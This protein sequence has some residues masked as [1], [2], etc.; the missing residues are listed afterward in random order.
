MDWLLLLF[1]GAFEVSMTFGLGKTRGAAGFEFC[2]C[3][4][5]F[6]I[7]AALSMGLLAKASQTLPLGT[8]YAVRTGI[9]AVG[10]VLVGI[11]VFKEP[12]A[13]LR[14]FFLFTLIAFLIGLKL[15]SQ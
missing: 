4:G 5:G 7:P 10:T 12:A 8:A 9:G 15:V 2:L 14:L 3:A 6:L 1:A 11:L 13:S